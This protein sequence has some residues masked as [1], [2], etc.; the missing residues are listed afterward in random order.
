MISSI[1]LYISEIGLR[2]QRRYPNNNGGRNCGRTFPTRCSCSNW[3]GLCWASITRRA[4]DW[5][6]TSGS[7]SY[8]FDGLV[9]MKNSWRFI[10][11]N[12]TRSLQQCMKRGDATSCRKG[13]GR[14]E[15][16]HHRVAM[17]DS[18]LLTPNFYRWETP[19]I[20]KSK[21]IRT[22]R[23]RRNNRRLLALG[24]LL[25]YRRGRLYLP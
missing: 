2:S 6:W 3:E 19:Y 14:E 13:R 25:I 16:P 12:P 21:I 7:N 4:R 18:Q 17:R 23:S 10:H 8:L 24:M 15:C 22:N 5:F 1:H 20:T 9:P 11:Y